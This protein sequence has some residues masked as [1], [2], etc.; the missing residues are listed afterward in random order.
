MCFYEAEAAIENKYVVELEFDQF[1][2]K[3]YSRK[4]QPGK[5]E[6][7]L[8]ELPTRI[9]PHELSEVRLKEFFGEKW[10]HIPD[11]VYKR[12]AFHPATFEVEEHH[13]AVYAEMTTRPS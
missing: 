8:K 1:C 13:M 12:L 6:D 4:K 2:T 3:P 11:K 10:K 5:R 9:I 7:D